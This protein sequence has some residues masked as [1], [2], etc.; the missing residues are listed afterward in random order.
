M[1]FLFVFLLWSWFCHLVSCIA[2]FVSE[3][4][5]LVWSLS[6][7]SPDP[8]LVFCRCPFLFFLSGWV[9]RRRVFSSLLFLSGAGETQTP[10]GG[11]GVPLVFLH[12]GRALRPRS[13][14]LHFLLHQG[15]RPA[16]F[17]LFFLYRRRLRGCFS[18]VFLAALSVCLVVCVGFFWW[19]LCIACKMYNAQSFWREGDNH[20]PPPFHYHG[21][22]FWGLGEPR[23]PD[24]H[25]LSDPWSLPP[26]LSCRM[27]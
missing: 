17:F 4:W 24:R 16:L 1:V 10:F 21:D 27:L 22:C 6:P 9:R 15:S 19:F 2:F 26:P 14:H 12:R 3:S 11:F 8:C 7:S 25:C 5:Y 13:V 20:L 18:G 23:R